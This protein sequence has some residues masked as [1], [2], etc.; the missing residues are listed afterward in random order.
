[1]LRSE[2]ES[3]LERHDHAAAPLRRIRRSGQVAVSAN[4]T[5]KANMRLCSIGLILP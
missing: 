1:M 4:A 2:N 5:Q 3:G